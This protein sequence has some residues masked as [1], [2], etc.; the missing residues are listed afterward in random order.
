V[1]DGRPNPAFKSVDEALGRLAA[2]PARKI[3]PKPGF[4]GERRRAQGPGGLAG[5]HRFELLQAT[6]AATGAIRMFRSDATGQTF[7]WG[8]FEG[9]LVVRGPVRC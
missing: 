2:N 5:P 6:I 8:L 7:P 4:L 9:G 1:G 3:D